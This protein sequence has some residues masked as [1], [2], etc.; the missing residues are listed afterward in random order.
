MNLVDAQVVLA[1]RSPRRA[2][3]LAQIGIRF[4]QLVPD[5]DEAPLDGEAPGDL[6]SRLAVAKAE[7]GRSLLA[8]LPGRPDLPVLAADTIVAID[9]A[10]LGKPRD[11]LHGLAMLERLSGR[12]HDVLTAVA[13]ATG[14]GIQSEVS[15][16]SVRF[17]RIPAAEAVRYWATGEPGDKAGG[18][19]I[20]G[21]GAVFVDRLEGSYSGVV[22]LPLDATDRLLAAVGVDCWRY[23]SG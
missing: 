21:I 23:R 13:V 4:L 8:G 11:R 5:V 10:A 6:V 22:G 18:Y 16:S 20:Q 7:A 3:L 15:R 9:G 12:V 14:A 1:S 2:E 17:R 19:A